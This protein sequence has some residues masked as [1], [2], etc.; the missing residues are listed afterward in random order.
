MP[1]KRSFFSYKVSESL[2]L[3]SFMEKIKSQDNPDTSEELKEL[4][5]Q[6]WVR[7][8]FLND[9]H[10]SFFNVRTV[11]PIQDVTPYLTYNMKKCQGAAKYLLYD[12]LFMYTYTGQGASDS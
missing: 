9:K 6:D 1:L 2:E 11:I 10:D 5:V 3:T 12:F 7:K 8:N 4:A